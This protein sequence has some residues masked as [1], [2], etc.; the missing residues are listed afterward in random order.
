MAKRSTYGTGI[1]EKVRIGIESAEDM[2]DWESW[3]DKHNSSG[4]PIA[5]IEAQA[6]EILQ[7]AGLPVDPAAYWDRQT[8]EVHSLQWYALES[9]RL[10]E[11]LNREAAMGNA[12]S[13]AKWGVFL[14]Q[15]WQEARMKYLFE[16]D[17][18]ERH[19]QRNERRKIA[20]EA[21]DSNKRDDPHKQWKEEA[22]R[23]RIERN[24]KGLP[25]LSKIGLAEAVKKNLRLT[26]SV[27]TI[28]K[29]I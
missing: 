7:N 16:P 14:G 6:R 20:K 13:A 10:T 28:R 15:L 12:R 26:D 2:R 23:I 25:K 19:R 27:H 22:D 11:Y 21:A 3:N 9:L 1:T 8:P 4:D 17:V 24:S 18:L 5:H 29:R